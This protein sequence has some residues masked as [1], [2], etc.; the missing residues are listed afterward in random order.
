MTVQRYSKLRVILLTI[1][2]ALWYSLAWVV[3]S[4]AAGTYYVTQSGAGNTDGSSLENAYSVAQF[5]ALSGSYAGSTFYFSGPLTSTV[6][7]NVYG[8]AGNY[9]TLDGYATDDTTFMDLDETEDGGRAKID[10]GLSADA[11]DITGKSY[12]IIQDFEITNCNDG[13]AINETSSN[14]IVRRNFI[15]EGDD[16]GISLIGNVSYVTIG[17]LPGHGNVIKNY[18]N[19]NGSADIVSTKSLAEPNNVVVSYNH[20]YADNSSWGV[21]GITLN[22]GDYWLIENNSI[23]DHDRGGS[24]PG[25]GENGIDLKKE[26]DYIVIRYN[27]IYGHTNSSEIIINGNDEYSADNIYIYGN[28]IYGNVNTHGIEWQ[29]IGGGQAYEDQYVWSNIIYDI[30][31]RGLSIGSAGTFHIFNN[32]L[33]EN[34]ATPENTTHTNMWVGAATVGYNNNIF[35]NGRPNESD[36]I[37]VYVGTGV[38]TNTTASNNVY[39]WLSETS[40]IRWDAL[41]VVALST[42]QSDSSYGRPEETN[43]V[44]DN[45][46]LTDYSGN[47][48]TIVNAS[49][50]AY[51]AGTDLDATLGAEPSFNIHGDPVGIMWDAAIGPN[52]VWGTGSTLPVIH[53]VNRDDYQWDAGA[54]LYADAASPPVITI[55]VGDGIITEVSGSSGHF[56]LNCSPT[57]DCGSLAIVYAFSGGAT[58]TDDYTARAPATETGITLSGTPT[59]QTP[60]YV[61]VEEDLIVEGSEW[62]TITIV[63]QAGYDLGSVYSASIEIQDND[64]VVYDYGKNA[65]RGGI[66]R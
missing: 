52:T 30:G 2:L 36:E 65:I 22:W 38:G 21:D 60:I 43:S 64:G 59:A 5:N 54:Y 24:Y 44:D 27:N 55:E 32:T 26:V 57:A 29:A 49:S 23:H 58:Y 8:L 50:G 12:I 62:I 6:D 9:V 4:Y 1:F 61:D 35:I 15:Y 56:H 33:S 11:I 40:T 39:Y 19:D 42:V 51:N 66:L 17:G 45:P 34:G 46:D 47:N 41:G 53:K 63:D 37:Q 16:D 18:G 7:V 13:V 20:L 25:W 10:P 28:R 14:I 3:L 31:H 48:Y